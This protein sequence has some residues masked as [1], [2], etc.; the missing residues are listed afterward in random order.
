MSN[1]GS[2]NV[3]IECH[4][5]F[6]RIPY[7]NILWTPSWV[8]NYNSREWG[9]VLVQLFCHCKRHLSKSAFNLWKLGGSERSLTPFWHVF[10]GKITCILQDCAIPMHMLCGIL[11]MSEKAFSHNKTLLLALDV[12]VKSFCQVY[13]PFSNSAQ[14]R[15][16]LSQ[17]KFI[18]I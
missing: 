10:V 7:H 15:M 2:F 1:Y 13:D 6:S 4:C 18:F 3:L 5:T 12:G 17:S 16:I 8:H 9:Q 14:A 11:A